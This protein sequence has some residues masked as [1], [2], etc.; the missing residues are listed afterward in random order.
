VEGALVRKVSSSK[1]SRVEWERWRECGKEGKR[2]R[3]A[4]RVPLFMHF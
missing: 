4:E 2:E 3:E 1:R